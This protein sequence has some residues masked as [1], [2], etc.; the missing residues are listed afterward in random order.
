MSGYPK[1]C[2]RSQ[3]FDSRAPAAAVRCH[4][5]EVSRQLCYVGDSL[6]DADVLGA[7]PFAVDQSP[8]CGNRIVLYRRKGA[9][10]NSTGG[11]GLTNRDIPSGEWTDIEDMLLLRI[12][13]R[14]PWG[15]RRRDT[16]GDET[17]VAILNAV[18]RAG[19][20][21]RKQCTTVDSCYGYPWIFDGPLIVLEI[22][23]ED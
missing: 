19:Y 2:R 18:Q 5:R 7:L 12:E 23:I 1:G 3:L 20:G 4:K 17:R 6:A 16:P 14:E 8:G 10:F 22:I 9:R 21:A 13:A 11:L 15:P